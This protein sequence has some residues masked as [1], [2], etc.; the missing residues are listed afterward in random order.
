[1]R[2]PAFIFVLGAVLLAGAAWASLFALSEHALHWSHLWQGD[3]LPALVLREIRLPRALACAL[4]GFALAMAGCLLQAVTRNPLASPHVLGINQGA[5]LFVAWSLTLPAN[6]PWL[7]LPM[8]MLGA[9][10]GG[11]FVMLLSGMLRGRSSGVRL[12]LSGVAVSALCAALTDG[13]VILNNDQA[14]SV[15]SFLA[16]S[17]DGVTWQKLAGLWPWLL[18]AGSACILLAQ[19]LNLLMLGEDASHSLGVN[20]VRLRA[21]CALLVVVLAGTVVA[22]V[23]AIAFV[24][25]IVPHIARTLL[26]RQDFRLLL[27]LSALLGAS[28][29]LAADAL[30]RLPRYP[31]ETPVGIITAL[32]GAPLFLYLTWRHRR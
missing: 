24:G 2:R 4:I 20:V 5:A 22:Y 10:L 15:V 23:G 29:M 1:M 30:S 6:G 18:A 28:L 8:A 19:R 13:I 16:G 27:P 31:F 3:G 26:Q 21:V 9:A 11:G 14:I 12:V 17:V 25:L 7:P 32:L